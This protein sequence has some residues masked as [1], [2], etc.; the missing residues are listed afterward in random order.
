MMPGCPTEGTGPLITVGEFHDAF[1]HDDDDTGGRFC[2]PKGERISRVSTPG[3]SLPSGESLHAELGLESWLSLKR[4][5]LG[6]YTKVL[7]VR[8]AL[9][10][11]RGIS[12]RD[13]HTRLSRHACI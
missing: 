9:P 8:R 7:Y 6:R 12:I 4:G 5:I 13:T 2:R 10:C 3:L 11:M 1:G